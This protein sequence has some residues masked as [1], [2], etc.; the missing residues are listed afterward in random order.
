MNKK[1]HI[2]LLLLSLAGAFLLASCGEDNPATSTT[3]DSSASSPSSS[4]PFSSSSETKKSEPVALDKNYFLSARSKTLSGG[5]A[6]SDDLAIATKLG[7]GTLQK[8]GPSA[9]RV[10]KTVYA[11]GNSIEG[12][13]SFVSSGALLYDGTS[14]K[15]VQ[16]KV[17]YTI[18]QNE[19]GE[20]TD[21]EQESASDTSSIGTSTFAKAIF[22][23]DADDIKSVTEV[24]DKRCKLEA[25]ALPSKILT[26][27]LSNLNNRFVTYFI[28]A[29]ENIDV[30]PTCSMY[31]TFTDDGYIAS[32]SYAFSADVT[33]M[34]ETQHMDVSYSLDFTAYTATNVTLPSIEG[35]AISSSEIEKTIATGTS[36]IS[37][38]KNMSKSSYS[39]KVKSDIAFDSGDDYSVTV[40]G[41][42]FRQTGTDYN[43]NN[44]YEVDQAGFVDEKNKDVDDYDGGRGMTS[45]G[46]IYDILDPAIGFKKYNEVERASFNES[47]DLFYFLF[48]VNS[49]AV[50]NVNFTQTTTKSGATTYNYAIKNELIKEILDMV[51]LSTRLVYTDDPHYNIFGEFSANSITSDAANIFLTVSSGALSKVQI[52]LEGSYETKIQ[53]TQGKAAYEL[54]LTI[55]C[56]DVYKTY[57]I[58][59]DN[60]DLISSIK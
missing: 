56:N 3:G 39:Y 1:K 43:F 31:V 46:K 2:K 4:S 33:V 35:L 21:F 22:E 8:D 24:S 48:D 25:K 41:E 12:Y 53:S 20:V 44:Y 5:Y 50:G 32:Y 9:K 38:Y 30:E 40:K 26:V 15:Y 7:I 11:P 57:E 10:G 17:L 58:P 34:G 23:Y 27:I 52:E 60:K 45:D 55:E 37:T 36:L 16:D 42:T 49:L 29:L 54:A 13:Q 14:T 19:D 59:S 28:S 18:K 6:Y 47:S 51:S